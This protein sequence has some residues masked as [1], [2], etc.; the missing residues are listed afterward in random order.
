MDELQKTLYAHWI[1]DECNSPVEEIEWLVNCILSK[2][3]DRFK[4]DIQWVL[5]H[6]EKQAKEDE[7]V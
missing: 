1:L 5:K 4:K 7:K 6:I 2:N 3:R